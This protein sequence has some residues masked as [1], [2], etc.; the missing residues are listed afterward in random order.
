MWYLSLVI[1][2]DFDRPGRSVGGNNS[3]S[4]AWKIM[5]C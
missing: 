1:Q 2:Q 4:L 3:F 5:K